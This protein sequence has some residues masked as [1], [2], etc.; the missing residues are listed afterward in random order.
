MMKNMKIVQNLYLIAQKK[1]PDALN[2]AQ[3]RQ[4]FTMYGFWKNKQEKPPKNLIF[5]NFG[6]IW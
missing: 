6:Q 1:R 4:L 5:E 3:K 2:A